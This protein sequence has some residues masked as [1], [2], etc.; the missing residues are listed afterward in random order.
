M[1]RTVSP[2]AARALA[3]LEGLSPYDF[4]SIRSRLR[5]LAQQQPRDAD[6]LT[7]LEAAYVEGLVIFKSAKDGGEAEIDALELVAS[8]IPL[9]DQHKASFQKIA[10]GDNRRLHTIANRRR[11]GGVCS[12]R[13]HDNSKSD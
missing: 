9:V 7:P 10:W 12:I 8:L 4:E 5:T 2:K 13:H 6:G 1:K 3:A 11:R